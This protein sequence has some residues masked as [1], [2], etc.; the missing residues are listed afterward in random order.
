MERCTVELPRYGIADFECSQMSEEE[1][2]F[3]SHFRSQEM[4][5]TTKFECFFFKEVEAEERHFVLTVLLVRYQ[6][7]SE[8]NRLFLSFSFFPRIRDHFFCFGHN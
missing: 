7:Y 4:V 8:Y 1:K 5:A 2:T 3:S 6:Q